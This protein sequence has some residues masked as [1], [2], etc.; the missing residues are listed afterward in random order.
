MS[1]LKELERYATILGLLLAFLLGYNA[2]PWLWPR[3]EVSSPFESY[4]EAEYDVK[5]IEELRTKLVDEAMADV[6]RRM[7]DYAKH[8]AEMPPQLAELVEAKAGTSYVDVEELLARYMSQVAQANY[9]AY[10][11]HRPFS[12]YLVVH[13]AS[14]IGL[15]AL[16]AGLR[17]FKDERRKYRL[18]LTLCVILA[19][20]GGFLTHAAVAGGETYIE[21][22][23]LITEVSYVIF[24]RDVDG[25]GVLDT[26]K[27]RDGE[28]GA[29]LYSGS[30]VVYAIRYACDEAG[31][32]GGG[33]VLIRKG[34]YEFPASE[35]PINYDN[36]W[37]RGEGPATIL[38]FKEGSTVDIRFFSVRGSADALRKNVII[39]DMTLDGSSLPSTH[40]ITAGY[41]EN[42]IFEKLYIKN[43]GDA[44][45]PDEGI[46]FT[47]HVYRSFIRNCHFYRTG[48]AGID[49]NQGSMYNVI[50]GN[51]FQECSFHDGG[52]TINLWQGPETVERNIIANNQIF[53]SK[54]SGIRLDG[55]ALTIVANNLIYNST[56]YGI[57]AYPSYRDLIIG[58]VLIANGDHH[59][60][61]GTGTWRVL[62]VSNS[63]FD[64]PT[65]KFAIYADG[66]SNCIFANLCNGNYGDLYLAS[67]TDGYVVRCNVFPARSY[68][69][70]TNNDLRYNMPFTWALK[71]QNQ[72]LA[73]GCINGT[74]ISH[75]LVDTPSLILLVVK[76]K[77]Y[78]AADCFLLNPSVI[79]VN[80]THFQ[81]EL[82]IVNATANAVY[83]VD[84]VTWASVDIYWYAEV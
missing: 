52:G 83:P 71:V 41:I 77:K 11:V 66:G 82:L 15:V 17:L 1:S 30:D 43:M 70:G 73:T 58:N 27:V 37:I 49:C 4:L 47:D 79:F 35:V 32:E 28:N 51:V 53:D 63:F 8:M 38:K 72:G 20:Y 19:F 74:Y 34:I 29:I 7:A 56:S 76:S 16:L 31:K 46:A 84:G 50:E 69:Y 78:Y 64:S 23:S 75:G 55:T 25:D 13:S 12:A 10:P 65:G 9:P 5:S 36:L 24:G 44:T 14:G 40:G 6:R 81:I 18:L 3:P 57:Y 45:Y 22:D 2:Y 54:G 59:L 61:L 42:C 26:F 62:V 33:V 48:S 68:D 67:A 60:Y 21:P 80:S 39:S